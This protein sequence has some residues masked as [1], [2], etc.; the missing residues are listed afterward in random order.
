[1][2]LIAPIKAPN[3]RPITTG[4]TT[5]RSMAHGPNKAL[6]LANPLTNSVCP[7]LMAIIA[8]AATNGPEL[9][10]IPPVI[11]TCETPRAIMPI[12]ATCKMMILRRASL[13]M[14]SNRSL[15]SNRKLWSFIY[16]RTCP[17]N[18]KMTMI[19]INANRTFN[20]LGQDFF[21]LSNVS[22]PVP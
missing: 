9:R 17:K 21:V 1:M 8:V 7:K 10:S 11:I 15:V 13:K 22:P 14:E 4:T 12:M 6:G 20:S 3:E 5:G 19:M 18:S 2:P 16:G